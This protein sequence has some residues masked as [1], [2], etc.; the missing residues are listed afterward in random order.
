MII[1]NKLRSIAYALGLLFLA[2]CN[3]NK[4]ENFDAKAWKDDKNGCKGLRKTLAS[5]IISR[6]QEIYGFTELEVIK[7]F[8]KPDINDLMRRQQ[9]IYHYHLSHEEAC[10]NDS[11]TLSLKMKFNAIDQVN[12]ILIE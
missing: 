9:K 4:F 1:K 5:E 3:N 8:G 10:P 12:E 7:S 6:K 2:A 11:T